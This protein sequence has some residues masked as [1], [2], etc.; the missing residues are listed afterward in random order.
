MTGLVYLIGA[1]P[2]DS[3]L[4]TV[5]GKECI[6]RADVIGIDL[7]R[8]TMQRPHHAPMGNQR[9]IGGKGQRR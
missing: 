1:G 7:C 8:E 9:I 2:G 4:I 5:K 3:K 6:E